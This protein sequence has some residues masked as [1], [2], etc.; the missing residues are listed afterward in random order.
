MTPQEFTAL[1]DNLAA[2]LGYTRIRDEEADG[3]DIFR[4][5]DS[6][7]GFQVGLNTTWHDSRLTVYVTIPN[8]LSKFRP[9]NAPKMQITVSMEK[10]APQIARDIERRLIPD[11]IPFG[12]EVQRRANQYATDKASVELI[13]LKFERLGFSRLNKGSDETRVAMRRYEP[14]STAID[15]QFRKVKVE[16]DDL[17]PDEALAVIGIPKERS[18][19]P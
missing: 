7:Q 15:I 17:T 9:Y 14:V 8:E 19:A 6:E 12:Q 4:R 3:Q 18:E 10:T 16:M 2:L 5:L 1:A 13:A 11:A